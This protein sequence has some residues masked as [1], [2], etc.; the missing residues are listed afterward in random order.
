MFARQTLY[1]KISLLLHKKN[2]PVSSSDV[3]VYLRIEQGSDHSRWV[4]VMSEVWING[5]EAVHFIM[6]N[7]N[8][9]PGRNFWCVSSSKYVF[10]TG[11][12][13][14]SLLWFSSFKNR[15][16]WWI[17]LQ[18][19]NPIVMNYNQDFKGFSEQCSLS[20]ELGIP[21]Y[22]RYLQKPLIRLNSPTKFA[23]YAYFPQN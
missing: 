3:G 9:N 22:L 12:D 21:C 13:A 11:N 1:M 23:F 8:T 16:W 10:H 6:I 20:Y 7:Y 19:Y 15:S 14:S 5:L 17:S 4:C 18:S 2:V